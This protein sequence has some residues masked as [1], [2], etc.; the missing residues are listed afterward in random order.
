MNIIANY[1]GNNYALTSGDIGEALSR[2]ASTLKS[3]G[4]GISD[5]MALV[6]GAQESIQNSPKVGR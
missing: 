1:I 5:S 2:S 4:V 3:Y 6:A